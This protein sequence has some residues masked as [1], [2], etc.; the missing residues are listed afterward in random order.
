MQSWR[1]GISG[2]EIPDE[3]GFD[4][5]GLASSVDRRDALDLR[6]EGGEETRRERVLHDGT[7]SVQIVEQVR[8]VTAINLFRF[9]S[10]WCGSGQC[11]S[12]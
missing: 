4:A 6:E 2:E 7:M 10:L 11:L 12:R 3:C 8:A 1:G 5:V 9:G